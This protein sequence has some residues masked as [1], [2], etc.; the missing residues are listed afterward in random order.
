[1]QTVF[2]DLKTAAQ[3]ILVVASPERS[4]TCVAEVVE[5]GNQTTRS[6]ITKRVPRY[7]VAD[8]PM[9]EKTEGER[10]HTR[11]IH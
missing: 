10:A 9:W 11:A 2:P 6:D 4:K 8:C 3:G 5:T 1:M 7:F